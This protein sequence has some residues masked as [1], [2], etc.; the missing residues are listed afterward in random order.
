[1]IQLHPFFRS[2]LIALGLAATVAVLQI[3]M[4]TPASA[5]AI[6]TNGGSIQGSVTDPTGAAIPGATVTVTAT[7]TGETHA[8]KTDSAGYYSIGPLI[9]G[10]YTISVSATNFRNEL[11]KTNV[12]IGNVTSGNV[13]LTLG[14]QSETVEVNAGALQINTDQIGVAGDIS[15]EQI[16]NLPI[17]GR[18]ILDVAQLQPGV[19]LQSGMSFD[20][21]KAGYSALSVSGVGGRTTRILLDGQDITDET[22]GTTIF[23]VPSGPIDEAQ[24]NRST[25]DISGEVTSTGQMLM[26]TR[27]GTNSFHGNVFGNFQDNRAG[28]APVNGLSAPFQRNQFGGYVGGPIWKDKLFFF[29]GG[30]RIKQWEE[31]VALGAN[32]VFDP[33][34]AQY[35]EVPAPFHDTYGTARVDYT[36][37]HN[38][39]MFARASYSVNADDATFGYG[40]YQIYQNRDNVPGMVGGA[41]VA[42]GRVTHSFRIG[43]EKFHNLLVDGTAALGSSIYNPSTGPNNQITLSGD[44]NAGPNFLAPQGT[45]QSDKQFRY[46]GTFTKG[47]HNFKFGG[48]SNRILSGGFADFYGPSLYTSLS[49]T[50]SYEVPCNDVVGA[51]LCPSNPTEGYAAALYVIGNGNG[52]FSERPGFNLPGGGAFSRRFAAYGG[53]T[54]KVTSYL[55]ITAGLR[56]SVDTDRANQDLATPLCSTVDPSMQFPGCTGNTPLFDQYQQGFGAPTHQPYGNFGPQLGFVYSPSDHKTSIRGGIGIFY[57][58]DVFNNSGN[59]RTPSIQADGPYFS[60]GLA[61]NGASSIQL[62]GYGVVTQAPDGTPVSTILS[63]SIA[64]AAPELN[65]IKGAYQA[66]VKNALTPN[67][68]YIGTGGGLDANSIYAAPYVSPYSIQINGG[69]QHDFGQGIIVSAD[70]VHNATMKVPISIDVNH[71]GAART[72]E[73][74]AATNAI[75]TTVAGMG[76]LLPT[77]TASVDCAIAQGADI[78]AFAAN[79]LDSGTVLLGGVA[80]SAYGETP[81]TGAAFP[82]T[83][84]NVGQGLFILPAGR[85]GY[86]ALQVVAQEQ[87]THPVPGL[88]SSN[89]QASYTLSR[90]VSTT[91]AAAGS[92]AATDQF[93][94]GAR[95]WDNDMPTSFMGRSGLDHTNELSFGGSVETMGG[96]HMGLIGHFYS[97]PPLNLLLDTGFGSTGQIFQTDV[98]GDGVSGDLVPGTVPGAYMHQIKGAQ[99]NQLIGNYNA[100]IAG[101][102]TP[103]G[104]ALIAAGLMTLPELQALKG[105]AQPI[106]AQP[107]NH[108][109]NDP[110]FRSFDFNASYPIKFSKLRE[111]LMITPG[112][113]MYNLFNMSN[114]N[115]QYGTLLNTASVANGFPL[116]YVNSPESLDEVNNLRVTRNSGTFDQGGPRTTEFQLMINF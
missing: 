70:Y 96:V 8:L 38:I 9:P 82:G 104:R 22:V 43:Y 14:N 29:G 35:P 100:K 50:S 41:D 51:A 107:A 49:A 42:I 56:W 15:K 12:K 24:L 111:G 2:A 67:S 110:A 32:P 36:A 6:S 25:Q 26:S 3:P 79:G 93:F 74:N 78:S 116:G 1:M 73:V 27:S 72:L 55:T 101:T 102:P 23:N 11:V 98:N 5:Q 85:S 64:N 80:A 10:N 33:I 58:S 86:D 40:P 90:I 44:L 17:N 81:D 71:D 54:W 18:N 75:A 89:L 45:F 115:L 7:D 37:P 87:K 66:K 59:A 108:P 69:V 47:S 62:P 31:D 28:F 4:A 95:A 46:D 84:P 97:A 19:I 34:L 53:D 113:A 99:L 52:F 105:V 91:A 88:N 13:K 63:E 21:T 61:F 92:N 76:C 68:G 48:E 30:E 20:P 106:A 114:Y 39:H 60:Y 65:A 83:N 109:A 57:E 103:A 16:D 112:V 77:I 94:G